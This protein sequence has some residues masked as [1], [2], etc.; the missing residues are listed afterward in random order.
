L[1]ESL[2]KRAEVASDAGTWEATVMHD[3]LDSLDR[4]FGADRFNRTHDVLLRMKSLRTSLVNI[5]QRGDAQPIRDDL[6][7]AQRFVES[8]LLKLESEAQRE[9]ETVPSA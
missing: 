7:N 3:N 6:A 5:A 8:A 9:S 1:Y 4:R 2:V